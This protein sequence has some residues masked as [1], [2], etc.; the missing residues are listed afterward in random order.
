[1][2]TTPEE[3]LQIH[4]SYADEFTQ[5]ATS[6]LLAAF[7]KLS[8]SSIYRYT[9]AQINITS[10]QLGKPKDVTGGLPRLPPNPSIPADPTLLGFQQPPNPDYGVAP[11]PSGESV[12]SSENTWCSTSRVR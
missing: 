12:C 8:D 9:P 6:A 2:G 7:A 5:L 4:K 10:P 1:M 11:K 3:I